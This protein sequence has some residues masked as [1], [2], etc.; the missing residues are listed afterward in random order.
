MP[1]AFFK[2][3]AN[4]DGE[5]AEHL[6]R[7]L[8]SH[9]VLAVRNEWVSEGEDSFWAFCIDYLE[10]S[11]SKSSAGQGRSRVDYKELLPPEQF[12]VFA[13][14]RELR[15]EMAEREGV[16]VF[17]LFTNE[18]LA[19]MV[20][21]GCRTRSALEKIDGIGE[22]RLGKYGDRFLDELSKLCRQKNTGESSE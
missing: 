6:N 9:R 4:D 10:G 1:F 19:E 3:R 15:K 8:R 14:L 16:P 18:Q 17:N 2:I 22:S 11:L 20:K 21:R 13:R 7:F 5:S 12:E